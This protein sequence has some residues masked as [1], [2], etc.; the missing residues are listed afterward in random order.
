ML[1]PLSRRCFVVTLVMEVL[2]GV[3]CLNLHIIVVL[4]CDRSS[5]F[6]LNISDQLAG[7]YFCTKGLRE[8]N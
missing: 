3:H 2:C 7:L 6:S 5:S 1:L 8:K 4:C